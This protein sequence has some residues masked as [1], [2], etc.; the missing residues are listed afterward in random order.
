MQLLGAPNGDARQRDG[1]SADEYQSVALAANTQHDQN[2]A[3]GAEAFHF[4]AGL[5]VAVAVKLP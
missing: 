2:I 1:H 4:V 3:V 5:S